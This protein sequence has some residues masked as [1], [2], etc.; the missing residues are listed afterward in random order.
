MVN[1]EETA[2]QLLR[3][4]KDGGRPN[5]A[6]SRFFSDPI[7]RTQAD[8]NSGLEF[9]LNKGWI[10]LPMP[11]DPKLTPAGRRMAEQFTSL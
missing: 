10:E 6:N 9:A 1:P 5:D 3:I 4:L 11:N 2:R 8:C 7:G